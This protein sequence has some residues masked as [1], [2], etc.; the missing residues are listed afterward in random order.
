M[1]C[2]QGVLCSSAGDRTNVATTLTGISVQVD[3][4]DAARSYDIEVVSSPSGTPVVLST[5]NLATST[6]GTS[7]SGLSVA[8][9]ANTEVGVRVVRATGAGASTF[10]DIVVVVNYQ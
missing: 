1:R 5:L 3:A 4:I 9:A 6:I 8:V 2:G 7:V 10:N